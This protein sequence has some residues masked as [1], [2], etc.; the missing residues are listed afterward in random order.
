M[1]QLIESSSEEMA[2]VFARLF[3]LAMRTEH[4]RFSGAGHY[5]RTPGQRGYPNGTKPKNI[6]TLAG[7]VTL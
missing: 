1:E 7:T 2:S 3:N 6:N 4:R 5:E